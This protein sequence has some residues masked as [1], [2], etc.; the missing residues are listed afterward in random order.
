MPRPTPALGAHVSVAGGLAE[1][2]RRGTDLDCEALQIFVK[3]PSQWQSKALLPEDAQAFEIVA[4]RFGRAAAKF[5][6]V[7]GH[8][9][10][11][12]PRASS[13]M[14]ARQSA[15]RSRASR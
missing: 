15:A 13:S 10:S 2:V 4:E 1:G 7:P 6:N 11:P 8:Q 5:K 9:L 14:L 3:S 12:L